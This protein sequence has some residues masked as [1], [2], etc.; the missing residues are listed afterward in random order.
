M[1]RL[2]FSLVN[3]FILKG[4]LCLSETYRK[5]FFNHILCVIHVMNLYAIQMT[6]VSHTFV[7]QTKKSK[8]NYSDG[9]RNKPKANK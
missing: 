7:T 3:Q 6:S 5:E 4:C 2:A 8:A 1:E 9:S